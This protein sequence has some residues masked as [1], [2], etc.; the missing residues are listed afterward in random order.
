MPKSI[1]TYSIGGVLLCPD[2][3]VCGAYRIFGEIISQKVLLEPW[4]TLVLGKVPG[5]PI[6]RV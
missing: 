6:A 3:K 1:P 2:T 4:H 5:P